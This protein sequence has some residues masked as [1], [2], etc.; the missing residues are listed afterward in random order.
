MTE[1]KSAPAK[2]TSVGG[3]GRGKDT[4]NDKEKPTHV[5]FDIIINLY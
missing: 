1:A 4:F 3:G 2:S 5:S